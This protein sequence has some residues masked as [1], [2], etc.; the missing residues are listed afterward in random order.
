MESPFPGLYTLEG[1]TVSKRSDM[2]K[3]ASQWLSRAEACYFQTSRDT[4][5]NP[6]ALRELINNTYSNHPDRAEDPEYRKRIRSIC[7]S[8]GHLYSILSA[9]VSGVNYSWSFHQKLTQR[10][11][12]FYHLKSLADPDYQRT[13]DH[14][15]GMTLR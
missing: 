15:A 14:L 1:E 6:E 12:A 5:D 13:I 9:Y 10:Y 3:L 4:G 7:S 11:R 8:R 2:A